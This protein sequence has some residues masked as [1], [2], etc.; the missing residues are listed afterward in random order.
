M[1]NKKKKGKNTFFRERFDEGR[2]YVVKLGTWLTLIFCVF[3]LIC[4]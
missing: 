1:G 4:D 2:D 3:V